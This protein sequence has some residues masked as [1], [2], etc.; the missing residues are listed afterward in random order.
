MRVKQLP[1]VD[2]TAQLRD[3]L[4]ELQA[5]ALCFSAVDHREYKDSRRALLRRRAHQRLLSASRAYHSSVMSISFL[6]L[7]GA[8]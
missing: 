3:R 2:I 5:A 7:K 6:G 8:P 1:K 4:D